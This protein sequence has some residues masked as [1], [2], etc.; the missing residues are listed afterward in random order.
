[1]A[2]ELSD[3][4]T[5]PFALSRKPAYGHRGAVATS[6]PV[7]AQAGMAMLEQGGNAVDAAI[8]TAMALAVVEP[9][10]NGLG[11]DAFALVWSEDTLHG[12]NAS[13]RAPAALSIDACRARG[14]ATTMPDFGWLPVTVPGAVS[15]WV[16]LHERFGC[17]P[18]ATLAVPA[19]ELAEHGFVATP[20][21]SRFWQ[22]A[23]GDYVRAALGPAGAAWFTT[24]AATGRGPLP[25]ELVRLPD[26]ARTLRSIAASTGRSFYEGE[27]AAA[28]GEFAA[29][30]GGVITAED[31]A[32][33]QPEWVTPIGTNYRGFDVWEIPPNGQGITALMALNMLEGFDIGALDVLSERAWHL[34]IEAIKLAFADANAYVSDPLRA[35]VPVIGMLDKSY[36]AA[37]RQLIT[38][39]ASNP[40]AGTP[41][42]GGTVYLCA[43]DG[44]GNMVSFI[45]SNYMGFGSG[46]VVP[47]TG[48]SLQNRGANFSLDGSHPNALEPGK[49]PYHTIIPGFLTRDAS[50]V[51]PFGV[52]GGFMQPQGHVQV[53]TATIDHHLHPQAALDAPRW[54]WDEQRRVI[55]EPRTPQHV[56]D[57]LRAR[58]HRVGI[59]P[60]SSAFGRGQMIWRLGDALVAGSES[61]ADGCALV[62]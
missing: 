31:L 8:A 32:A 48:I 56:V 14:H 42:R 52:M 27:L 18:F 24:F 39:E 30:T 46:V 22:A 49:R 19:I 10:S 43:A 12:L 35:D 50:A 58:G 62:R 25:G 6:Q 15:Q 16:A 40:T 29:T 53:I 36:A 47:G 44:D 28:I 33:H 23:V 13:G 59:E 51:G 2:L 60:E 38:E 37:R 9:T 11:S 34:K 20:I 26:H 54:R 21:V 57:A 55:V 4:S 3:P 17:L 5:S 45:Q 7:A 41:P 1:M 61:R